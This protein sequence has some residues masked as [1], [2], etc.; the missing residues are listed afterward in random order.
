MR[1]PIAVAATAGALVLG[2]AAIASADGPGGPFGI[3]GGGEG[4]K[5]FSRDLASKLDGVS[6]NEVQGALRDMR[7]ER[8]AEH[9]KQIAGALAAEL[10]LDVSEVEAAVVKAEAN[11]RRQFRQ[12]MRRNRWPRKDAFVDTLAVELDKSKAEIRRA[13]RAAFRKRFEAMLDQ[14]VEDGKLTREQADRIREHVKDGPPGGFGLHHRRFDGPG[15]ADGPGD[16]DGP[17]ERFGG[18]GPFGVHPGGP[19][20]DGPPGDFDGPGDDDDGPPG[21]EEGGSDGA[22]GFQVP[23]PPPRSGV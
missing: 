4:E 23:V 8:R 9:R 3:G 10:D 21:D 13:M 5:E 2:G 6:P 7:R 14:A 1:R 20:F 15:D 18:P 11:V 16:F 22:G 17:G 12:S 19:G